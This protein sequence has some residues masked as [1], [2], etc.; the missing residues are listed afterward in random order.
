MTEASRRAQLP[1]G[2]SILA[3]HRYDVVQ[4]RT[5]R[6]SSIALYRGLKST[7]GGYTECMGL[8][9]VARRDQFTDLDTFA[10]E[11][12][13]AA[14]TRWASGNLIPGHAYAGDDGPRYPVV[15]ND[16]PSG[17]EWVQ[18]LTV[19]RF[20]FFRT[21]NCLAWRL[22]VEHRA[23]LFVQVWIF[24]SHGGCAGAIQ[25]AHAVAGSFEAQA[26]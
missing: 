13:K 9:N 7:M 1:G 2:G 18:Q 19:A 22:A 17:R 6:R 16:G 24:E 21:R 25:L 5:F 14:T 20:G 10:V 4:D 15:H 23:G 12:E 26:G 3:P 11:V 8:M